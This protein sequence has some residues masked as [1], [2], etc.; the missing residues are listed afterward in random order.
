MSLNL[1]VMQQ[2]INP[3]LVWNM[4]DGSNGLRMKLTNENDSM[5]LFVWFAIPGGISITLCMYGDLIWFYMISWT[6]WNILMKFD[7]HI[8]INKI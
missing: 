1:Y 2:E 6:L 8:D 7:I 4:T 5:G 3:P